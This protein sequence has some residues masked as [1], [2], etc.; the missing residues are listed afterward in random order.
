MNIFY[1][2]IYQY[3]LCREM[4]L[5][6]DKI[7]RVNQLFLPFY[8]NNY[9]N[10]KL[11]VTFSTQIHVTYVM[12]IIV[13]THELSFNFYH[14][15]NIIKNWHLVQC[16]AFYSVQLFASFNGLFLFTTFHCKTF[17]ICI[18]IEINIFFLRLPRKC[19]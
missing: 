9:V 14:I 13:L 17:T 16:T 19:N 4:F 15:I 2:I 3:C 11:Q 12:I 7:R 10:V 6:S 18:F 5:I 1:R 8:Q